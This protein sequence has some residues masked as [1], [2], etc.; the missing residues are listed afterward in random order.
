MAPRNQ[1][2]ASGAAASRLE[3]RPPVSDSATATPRSCRCAAAPMHSA[4]CCCSSM[5]ESL[6][7]RGTPI[8]GEFTYAGGRVCWLTSP[9]HVLIS[10]RSAAVDALELLLRTSAAW[11][12]LHQAAGTGH[13]EP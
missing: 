2:L 13:D 7:V 12:H 5:L 9:G 8:R 10:G 1:L 11:S 6:P 4:S 3:I